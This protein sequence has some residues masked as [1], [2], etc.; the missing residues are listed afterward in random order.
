MCTFS[1][2][3]MICA[4]NELKQKQ[5]L[6]IWE[7]LGKNTMKIHI[8]KT[9]IMVTRDGIAITHSQISITRVQNFFIELIKKS[10]FI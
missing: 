8:I 2:D 3:L 1:D 6:K 9:K 10:I 4:P 5:N 7:E